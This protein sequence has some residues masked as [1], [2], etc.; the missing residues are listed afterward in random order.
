MRQ[1]GEEVGV[2]KWRMEEGAHRNG[3][4]PSMDVGSSWRKVGAGAHRN[5]RF[6]GSQ[7]WWRS[8]LKT[9]RTKDKCQDTLNQTRKLEEGRPFLLAGIAMSS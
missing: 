8:D 5:G 7:G 2:M 3:R 4:F 6:P 1:E 9:T